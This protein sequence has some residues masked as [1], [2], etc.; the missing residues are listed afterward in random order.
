M[1]LVEWVQESPVWIVIELVYHRVLCV[2]VYRSNFDNI[3]LNLLKILYWI[4]TVNSWNGIVYINIW[5]ESMHGCL[6]VLEGMKAKAWR[7]VLSKHR[8]KPQVKLK[9]VLMTKILTGGME[10]MIDIVYV[11][12]FILLWGWFS[13]TFNT[14]ANSL[15]QVLMGGRILMLLKGV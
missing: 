11:C 4:L 6:L 13:I 1:N 3:V 5:I 15:F 14:Y 12:D 9:W 7:W 10:M 2:I 8:C